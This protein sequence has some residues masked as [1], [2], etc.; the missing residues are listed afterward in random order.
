[1]ES[2]RPHNSS[3]SSPKPVNRQWSSGFFFFAVARLAQPLGATPTAEDIY[4]AHA[5]MRSLMVFPQ[6]AIGMFLDFRTQEVGIAAALSGDEALKR[7]Y[8]RGDIYHALALMCGLTTKRIRL[9]G[10]SSR[11]VW[12]A[13]GNRMERPGRAARPGRRGEQQAI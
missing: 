10:R 6:D 9:V 5:G 2:S 13:P 3:A 4:N 1:M 11:V 7:D 12:V 8:S